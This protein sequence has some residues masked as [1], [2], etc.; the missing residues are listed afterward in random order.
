MSDIPI[1]G[2]GTTRDPNALALATKRK[3]DILHTTR[4]E[5]PKVQLQAG[6]DLVEKVHPNLL[7]RSVTAT[8]NC[9][10][11][12][13]GSRRTWI[14]NGAEVEKILNDDGYVPVSRAEVVVGDIILYRDAGTNEINHVGIVVHRQLSESGEPDFRILSKW[15]AHPEYIHSE[16]QTMAQFGKKIEFCSER[17][18]D[19]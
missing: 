3:N 5:Q 19:P 13:F 7:R 14:L 11:M 16:K 18:K 17:K 9:F 1:I 6:L 15:G 12:V 2:E 8:Y 10:G 4:K